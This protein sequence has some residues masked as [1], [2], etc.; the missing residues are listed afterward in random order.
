LVIIDDRM[1]ITAVLF[2]KTSVVGALR[3]QVTHQGNIDSERSI[4]DAWQSK[5]IPQPTGDQFNATAMCCR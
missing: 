3:G 1:R 2:L 4:I 5:L